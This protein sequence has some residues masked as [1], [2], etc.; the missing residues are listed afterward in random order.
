MRERNRVLVFKLNLQMLT[1][2]RPAV[3]VYKTLALK[4]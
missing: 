2:K 1:V 3:R 4:P